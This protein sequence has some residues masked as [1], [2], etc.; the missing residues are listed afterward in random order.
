MLARRQVR[1]ST[2]SGDVA[3]DMRSATA[4]TVSWISAANPKSS[5]PQ[6]PVVSAWSRVLRGM[7]V[8][9]NVVGMRARAMTMPV[10]CV[11]A[12]APE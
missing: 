1:G 10:C 2:C 12:P 8:R 6:I 3:P 9:W 11:R 7:S 4:S 5:A